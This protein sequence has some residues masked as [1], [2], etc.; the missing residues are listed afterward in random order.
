VR[1]TLRAFPFGRNVMA[2]L[3]GLCLVLFVSAPASATEHPE[4][5]DRSKLRVC[6]DP[7][8][9]PY[10]NDK[11]EGFENKI[12]EL[13]AAKLNVP[14]KY[15]WYPNTVGF[16]RNTLRARRC[17]LVLGIVTGAELVQSTNPYYRSTYV[18]VSRTEDGIA[19]DT[20]EALPKGTRIGLTAGAPPADIVAKSGLASRTRPYNLMVDTRY[21]S[22]GKDMIQDLV[23]KEIDVA[24]LWGPIAGYFAAPHGG[25]LKMIPLTK[26]AAT[27]RM[28][29]YITMAVRPGENNWK[30]DINAL[31]RENQ[32]EIS[33]IL[34]S[35][36]IP[37]LDARRN[38]VP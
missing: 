28:E 31:I 30:N 22:P 13:L 33:A 6:A 15:I 11:G 25:Q 24:L 34:R 14:L 4:A 36:H 10:S 5:V 19:A 37:T 2:R 17:D 3:A 12:A 32:E 21:E 1:R 26:E 29:F 23:D 9:L 38:L 20:I 8:N 27:T 18:M 7:S 16:L 35:Y